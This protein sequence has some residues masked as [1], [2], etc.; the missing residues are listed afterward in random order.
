MCFFSVEL[1]LDSFRVIDDEKGLW[2]NV[3]D[4]GDGDGEDGEAFEDGVCDADFARLLRSNDVMISSN[5]LGCL[6]LIAKETACTFATVDISILAC[7]E[8]RA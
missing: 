6:H 5:S 8:S 7:F 2:G 3:F 4:V 1:V